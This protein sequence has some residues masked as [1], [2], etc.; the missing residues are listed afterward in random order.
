MCAFGYH[1]GNW[2]W[3]GNGNT[4]KQVKHCQRHPCDYVG[5]RMVHDHQATRDGRVIYVSDDD[6]YAKGE[7]T[8]CGHIG[9][10]LGIVHRWGPFSEVWNDGDQL[11]ARRYCAHC[12]AHED[13][14]S[15]PVDWSN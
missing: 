2:R 8:R 1:S 14:V 6:C 5:E 10:S 3:A 15:V 13:K 9:G 12:A 11:M 7:C 4:C